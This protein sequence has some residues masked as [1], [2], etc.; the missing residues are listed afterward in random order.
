MRTINATPTVQDEQTT[1]ASIV[2]DLHDMIAGFRCAGTGRLVKAGVS[3]TH[4]HVMWLLA[5]H[6]DLHMGHLAEWLDVSMSNATG[7][8][9]RMEERGLVERVR[10]PDDRRVVL[11]RLTPAG[12]QAL[13]AI[14]AIKQDRLRGILGHLDASQLTGVAAALADLRTAVAAEMGPDYGSAHDHPHQGNG[15]ERN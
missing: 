15:R 8:V 6:G 7:I 12:A 5:H 13:E 10:V 14:E 3:M 1:I 4:M 11:V 2:A 9:D